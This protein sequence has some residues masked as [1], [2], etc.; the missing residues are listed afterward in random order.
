MDHHLPPRC[1]ILHGTQRY[2]A[3]P[4]GPLGTA[5]YFKSQFLRKRQFYILDVHRMQ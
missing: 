2:D 1:P 3:R 5:F 4:A